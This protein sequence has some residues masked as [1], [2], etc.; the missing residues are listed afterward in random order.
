MTA[1]DGSDGTAMGARL[2]RVVFLI[3]FGT[4][5]FE[6][7]LIRVLSFTI[8]YHFAYVVISTALLGFGASGALLAVRPSVG[9]GDLPRTLARAS[10]AAAASGALFFLFMSAF[11][12][13]PLRILTSGRAFVLMVAYQIGATLPFFFGGIAISLSLREGARRVDR[14]YFWDLVGAGLACAL[15]IWLMNELTPPGAV[16]LSCAVLALAGVAA[17][18]LRGA[19]LAAALGALLVALSPFAVRVPFTPAESKHLVSVHLMGQKLV[20]TFMKWTSLFRTDVVKRGSD[21]PPLTNASEWGLSPAYDGEAQHAWGFLTHDASAGA[22]IYDLREGNA[23][24]LDHHILRLPYL[25]ATPE[26]RVLVIGVGG[27]RDLITA[28]RY[29]ASHVTGV[30]LDPVT[31]SLI[32]DDLSRL[33]AGAFA[34]PAVELHAGEGRH[35]I[36]RSTE[37]YDVIQ[38]TGV[39]TLAAQASGAYVLAENYLYTEEAFHGY[40]DHLAPRGILSMGLG[41]L[42]PE[43]PQS[44]GRMVLIARKALQGRG[45]AHPEQHLIAVTSNFIQVGLLVRLEPFEVSEVDH[46][47]QEIA[48]PRFTPLLLPGRKGHPVYDAL[49]TSTGSA[50]TALFDR[51]PYLIQPVTDEQ[52]FFFR[53]FR[54]GDLLSTSDFGAVHT[55]AL[56]QLV[57]L[58]LLVSLTVLGAVFI[59]LP[60]AFFLRGAVASSRSAVLVLVYFLSIGLGFMMLEISLMQRF[61]LFLGYPTFALSVVLLSLLGSLGAGSFL[62]KR[63]VGRERRALPLALLF[64]ACIVVLYKTALPGVLDRTIGMSLPLRI[65]LTIALLAP[66]GTTLGVFFPLGIRRAAEIHPDLVP[67]AWGVNGCASVVASVASI[68]LAMELGFVA[69]WV[70]SLAIYAVGVAAFLGLARPA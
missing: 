61:V 5:L 39:D 15:S 50:R 10:V 54:W 29:G 7:S 38:I 4:L 62:S 55:T 9:T 40:L 12:F 46:V 66:L 47:V 20:P 26:P 68:I 57:L 36:A 35:F 67:W 24:F 23:E 31:V 64:V 48:A 16:I 11:P 49:M 63:W 1:R 32:R 34:P 51:L 14:L 6:I 30:E 60:L 2:S 21:S 58:V 19:P 3:A 53:F 42:V 22:P 37:R 27:G 65:A 56:G 52:P 28:R 17:R 41:E 33:H 45:I 18:G 59:L 8:W 13:D 69:V 25:V 43:Q 70:S 44:L